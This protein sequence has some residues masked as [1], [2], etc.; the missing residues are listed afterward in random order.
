MCVSIYTGIINYNCAKPGFTLGHRYTRLITFRRW[1]DFEDTEDY[2]IGIFP[3]LSD[4]YR[5]VVQSSLNWAVDGHEN[6]NR[7][8]HSSTDLSNLIYLFAVIEFR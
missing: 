7:K 1:A 6:D 4:Y 8:R 2:K 5:C 3:N